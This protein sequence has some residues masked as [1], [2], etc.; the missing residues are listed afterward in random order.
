MVSVVHS[1]AAQSDHEHSLQTLSEGLSAEEAQKIRLAADFAQAV[2][3]DHMLGS[4]EGVWR[5][6]LGMAL[7]LVGLK[8]DADSRLAALL[9][10]V[11]TYDEQGIAHIEERFGPASAHLVNGISRLNRLRPITRGFVAHSAESGEDNPQEMKAQIEVLRK[12]LLAMVEDIRVVLLRLASRTQTLRYYAAVPDDL[13]AQVA[14]ETLELYSPLANRLGVWELKWELEDLSFRF[15][16][17]YL[18]KKIAKELD[19]KRTEREQF[20]ADAIVRLKAELATVGIRNAEVYG[21]PKHIYSIWNKM[22]KKDVAFSEVY[23]VRALRVIVH[24][25]KDCYTALGIVHNIWSPISKEFDDYISNPKGNNYR[26]LHTAVRCPD[27]RSLEVQI[28]TWEMHRHSELGVA[29][30]WRYKEGNKAASEDNYDEK[31]AWLRQLLTWKDE[32]ADSSDWVKHYKEAALDETIYIMTPQGRV[33]DLPRGATPVDFAYRVHTDLGH[34]CRGAKVDGAL[35]PLNTQLE[36][37]QRVEI[38]LAKHGGPSRDWLNNTLGYLFTHRAR[39]KARHWFSS[40]ALEETLAD[41]RAIVTR[42]LQR[43]GQNSTNLDDLAAKLGFAKSED[44]F[45]A[46]ARAELNTR[47]LQVAVRGSEMPVDERAAQE[48]PQRKHKASDAAEKGI[49]IVGVDKLLT[50]LAGC[51]KPA[52]PDPILGFVT[53]GKGVS[54]HRADCSNFANMEAMHPER[55]IETEWGGQAGGIFAVDI[56]VDAHDRQ[57][58]LRD[59]SEVFTREKINVIAVNTQSRQGTAHMGFTAE[60]GNVQQLKRTLSLIHDVPGVVGARRA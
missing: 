9:F 57:G 42:E 40:L 21:R 13:R 4:G 33:V 31:I 12:M 35:V 10:A 27:G 49:L 25:V 50:Q 7:I 28:R 29:A 56:V 17:P 44:M 16:H 43:M 20:I 15:L 32:V 45:I 41:G 2:Y 54:I 47:Q 51:C 39:A 5:H 1:V 11:P 6:A 48:P 52:P 18:Y 26:S 58:L 36:T 38:V 55:V 19:E 37:G 24:E 59:I 30:H 14:R 60:I 53:R 34:R 22:R 8:L 3:A 46:V 23:D